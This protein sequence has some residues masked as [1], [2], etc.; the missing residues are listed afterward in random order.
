M[1]RSFKRFCAAGLCG[2]LILG[3]WA[4][5][6]A[7]DISV[8]LNGEYI[9]F[10]QPPVI[11]DDRTLVPLRAIFEAMGASVDWDDSIKAVIAVKD[12]VTIFLQIGSNVL[13]RNGEPVY[14][15]VAAQIVNDRTMVPARAVAESFGAEVG[16]D[17]ETR[18]V[19]ITYFPQSNDY[20]PPEPIIEDEENEEWNGEEWTD[21]EEWNGEENDGEYWEDEYM[22]G[23]SEWF[24]P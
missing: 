12:D 13:L 20:E 9:E 10:D 4:T 22:D 6:S 18:T 15:D 2:L 19:I 11:V 1:K 5:T 14:L 16:W 17:E 21:G 8:T 3:A 23:P 24:E 7:Q